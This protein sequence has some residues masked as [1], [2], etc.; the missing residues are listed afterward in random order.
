M[1]VHSLHKLVIVLQ[2]CYKESEAGQQDQIWAEK[3]NVLLVTLH[4]QIV[5][6]CLNKLH[7]K[8]EWHYAYKCPYMYLLTV[9]VHCHD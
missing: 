6:T 4:V 8:N 5:S 1:L 2:I 3:K 9:N 7:N